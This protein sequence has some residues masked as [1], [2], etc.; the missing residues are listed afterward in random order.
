M[1]QRL[2]R[3]LDQGSGEIAVPVKMRA[4][5][6][7]TERPRGALLY[8]DIGFWYTLCRIGGRLRN[9]DASFGGA[10]LEIPPLV[11]WGSNLEP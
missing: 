10:N 2:E 11:C 8:P 3:C 1:A 7:R 5:R 6:D 4:T 9:R